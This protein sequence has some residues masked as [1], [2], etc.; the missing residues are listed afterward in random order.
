[1]FKKKDDYPQIKRGFGRRR[2]R[3]LNN[4]P[5]NS[6]LPSLRSPQQR[7]NP[8]AQA[9]WVAIGLSI[10]VLAGALAGPVWLPVLGRI[11]P[12]QYIM[13]YAPA[14][15]QNTMLQ[16]DPNAQVPTPAS[17]ASE[18]EVASLLA[19]DEPTALPPTPAEPT[20][21]PT[22]SPTVD[23][24]EALQSG[25]YAQQPTLVAVAPT[26]TVTP[27]S[28]LS[29]DPRAVD[30]ENASDLTEVELLLTGFEFEQQG[31]NN[32]GPASIRTLMSYWGIDFTEEE[33]ASYLKP[34]ASDA[35]VRPDEMANYAA[36]Y[37]W[38]TTIRVDGSRE[39]LQDFMLAG[40]PVMIETGYDPE[41]TTVGW[42]SHYLTMVGY[43]NEGFIA[44]DT[45]RRPN[46]HY[47]YEEIDTFWRQF[48]RKYLVF[49]R[50]DQR[51]A[52]ESIILNDMQRRNMSEITLDEDVMYENARLR[53]QQELNMDR[54]DPF[55]WYNLGA[56]LVGL[57]RYEDAVS[58][59]NQA[60][61]IGLPE[62]FPWYQF[63]IYEAYFETGNYEEVIALADAVLRRQPSEEAY[64]WRGLAMA[65][66]GDLNSARRELNRALSFN[67]NF[68]DAAI[69]LDALGDEQ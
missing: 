67:R 7:T 52:V 57:G 66:E 62:R 22:P 28:A 2:R 56:S 64:Y 47:P 6:N 42:T 15:L 3:K 51:T 68:R 20:L 14:G 11:I 37:G 61:E 65:A 17:S 9:G 1:M 46:W 10:L 25:G 26:P 55:G 59:F 23:V 21:T 43:T 58:A 35:N 33:A 53:A 19:T 18:E 38:Q 60:R 32:C 45:Y 54:E 12:K 29:V 5:L 44:M 49:H 39:L 48:N 31:L 63:E 8:L 34:T 27:A 69:A 41:P 16:I 50:A 36:E 30:I 4:R 40:Y 13:A 24:N